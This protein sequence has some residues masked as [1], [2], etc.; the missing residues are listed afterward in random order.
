MLNVKVLGSGCKNCVKLTEEVKVILQELVIEAELEKVEDIP[1]ILQY[2]VMRTPGLVIN[3]KVK[4]S[5]RI[6]R[7]EEIVKYI[8]EEL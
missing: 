4:S 5:G 3:N 2:G 6:P 1:T 7:K 8:Q